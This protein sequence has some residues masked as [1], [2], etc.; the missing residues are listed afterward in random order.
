MA[1]RMRMREKIA[2]I[3][4]ALFASV[5]YGLIVYWTVF[6]RYAEK[7]SQKWQSAGEECIRALDRVCQKEKDVS[8]RVI[9]SQEC[10]LLYDDFSLFG[11]FEC[12]KGKLYADIWVG[13][14]NYS[15]KDREV[16]W[17]WAR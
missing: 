14:I 8:R 2:A 15:V 10:S 16:V 6:S 7:V 5:M 13:R 17:N 9:S 3:A 11:V 1:K 4:I 12:R